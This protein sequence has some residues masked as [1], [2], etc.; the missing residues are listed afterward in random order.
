MQ[1]T[2]AA[3]SLLSRLLHQNQLRSSFGPSRVPPSLFLEVRSDRD[4]V[5]ATREVAAPVQGVEGPIS[6]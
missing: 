6:P 4:S 2:L 1:F 3:D 5:R